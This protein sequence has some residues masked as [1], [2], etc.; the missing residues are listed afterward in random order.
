MI[1]TSRLIMHARGASR[2][3]AHI[4]RAILAETT[5]YYVLVT[6]RF[7]RLQLVSRSLSLIHI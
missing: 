5:R 4:R 7:R 6:D 3:A 2:E 1:G